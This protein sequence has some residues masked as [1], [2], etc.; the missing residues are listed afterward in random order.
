MGLHLGPR[1]TEIWNVA[2]DL[3]GDMRANVS[4][5]TSYGEAGM[6][7]VVRQALQWDPAKRPDAG[8]LLQHMTTPSPPW[9][10][11]APSSAPVEHELQSRTPVAPPPTKGDASPLGLLSSPAAPTPKSVRGRCACSGHCLQPGH[12]SQQRIHGRACES[13]TVL[14]GCSYCELCVC[15]VHGCWKPRLDSEMCSMHKKLLFKM[16]W[17]VQMCMHTAPLALDMLPCDVADFLQCW[18]IISRH[19]LW[20]FVFAFLR[21]PTATKKWLGTEVFA[22]EQAFA[23]TQGEHNVSQMQGPNARMQ[24]SAEVFRASLE[25]VV[26]VTAREGAPHMGDHDQLTE[27]AWTCVA[28][29]C[30]VLGVLASTDDQV[31]IP[32]I[33][34][35]YVLTNSSEVIEKVIAQADKSAALWGDVLAAPDISTVL[36]STQAWLHTLHTAVPSMQI[37]RSTDF[38]ATSFVRKVLLAR[39]GTG[40]RVDWSQVANKDLHDWFPDKNN[41][42]AHFPD[43]ISAA[44]ISSILF[45]RDDWVLMASMYFGLWA[46][47]Q[48]KYSSKLKSIE[49]A[50]SNGIF[51]KALSA[52][53]TGLGVTPTPIAVVDS[54]FPQ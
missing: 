43:S 37:Q 16:P 34:G 13:K 48:Q 9:N 50:M 35:T 24:C 44:N 25:Q 6:W 29:T 40:L 23:P 4:A 18:P 53:R 52:L 11:V 3:V 5:V 31:G 47:V 19:G 51:A 15:V 8:A 46:E 41:Y 17:P 21:E 14:Q 10:V 28:A 27:R 30:C 1:Y 22:A 39:V 49:R 2:R 42:L 45:G 7:A 36:S 12:K 54:L 26:T 38:L 20:A 32:H 33:Q